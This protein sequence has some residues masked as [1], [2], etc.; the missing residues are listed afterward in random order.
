M[1]PSN[2]APSRV[3]NLQVRFQL[4]GCCEEELM[5]LWFGEREVTCI[6]NMEEQWWVVPSEILR[7][8]LVRKDWYSGSFSLTSSTTS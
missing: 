7:R 5:A 2:T 8:V 6:W 4:S 3:S 1:F